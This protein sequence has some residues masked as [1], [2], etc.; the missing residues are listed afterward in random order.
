MSSYATSFGGGTCIINGKHVPS[1]LLQ[2]NK[3]SITSAGIFVDGKKIVVDGDESAIGEAIKSI[4]FDNCSFKE[5]IVE[6]C[7]KMAITSSQVPQIKTGTGDIT[8]DEKCTV[9]VISTTSGD[10]K[11]G[12][13]VS[14]SC[15]T[16]SGDINVGGHVSG[17]CSTVSGDVRCC[18][19]QRS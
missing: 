8:V 4:S 16:V 13:S 10:V 19:R 2:G 14:G 3:V 17:S 15:S 11:A 5:L 18:K 7:E 1:H 9:S 12:G 6:S